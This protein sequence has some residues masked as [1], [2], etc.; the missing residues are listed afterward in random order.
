MNTKHTCHGWCGGP[1]FLLSEYFA[2][3]EQDEVLPGIYRIILDLSVLE[4]IK[5]AFPV[6]DGVFISM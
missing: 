1:L 3:I 5:A 4:T 6:Q 2:G